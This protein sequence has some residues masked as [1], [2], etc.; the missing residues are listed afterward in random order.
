MEDSRKNF[1]ADISA[2][3][4][5]KRTNLFEIFQLFF[6]LGKSF[7]NFLKLPLLHL[8]VFLQVYNIE[9]NLKVAIFKKSLECSTAI[10]HQKK[11]RQACNNR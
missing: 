3:G 5:T 2:N 11:T 6:S 1:Y 10:L 8:Q 4:R 7:F 9:C